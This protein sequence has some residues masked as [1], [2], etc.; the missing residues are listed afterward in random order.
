MKCTKC[1]SDIEKYEYISIYGDPPSYN[2][3]EIFLVFQNPIN[4]KQK[5]QK[6][7]FHIKQTFD[8]YG[9]YK[10]ELCGPIRELT[11]QEQFLD[12]IKAT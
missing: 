7:I 3:Y 11:L 9:T 1:Q 8:K 12:W 4:K 5:K 10:R 6:S 2:L